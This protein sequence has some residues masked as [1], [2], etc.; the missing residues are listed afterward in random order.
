MT[1]DFAHKWRYVQ[2]PAPASEP[3]AVAYTTLAVNAA[4]LPLIT[5]ALLTLLQQS[6]WQAANQGAA[7]ALVDEATNL[8]GMLAVASGAANTLTPISNGSPTQP[9]ISNG[10]SALIMN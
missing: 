9:F 5:G 2:V 10:N 7:S 6:T 8:L 4:W 1:P 3:A